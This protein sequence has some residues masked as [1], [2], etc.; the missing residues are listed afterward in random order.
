MC[1]C[2]GKVSK[3][4]PGQEFNKKLI[5]KAT[6]KHTHFLKKANKLEV[7]TYSIAEIEVE[8]Y[9]RPQELTIAHTFCPFCGEKY[10]T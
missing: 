1:E 3:Q 8:G 10:L 9:V 2:V 5:Q 7:R 6:L 4:I